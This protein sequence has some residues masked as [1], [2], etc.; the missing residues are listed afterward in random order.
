MKIVLGVR[1]G[2]SDYISR[3]DLVSGAQIHILNAY[4][5]Y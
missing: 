2:A 5:I 3:N 1:R 4:R